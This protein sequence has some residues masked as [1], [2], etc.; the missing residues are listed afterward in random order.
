MMT[1][2]NEIKAN[3]P[4][5]PSLLASRR[6]FLQAGVAALG[7]AWAGTFVQSKLFA[8]ETGQTARPVEFALS[9]LAVGAAKYIAYAGTPVIVIR[10]AESIRAFSLSCTHLGCTVTW[11]AGEKKFY[12]PCHEGYF[13]Q[14]GEVVAGPPPVPLEQIP[15]MVDGDRVIVGEV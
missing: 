4:A 7:A 10:T 11:Q 2:A 14:F 12:C 9:E 15:V 6:Q 3:N 1:E 8:Q 13:D 5:R